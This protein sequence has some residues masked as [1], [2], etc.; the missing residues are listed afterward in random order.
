MGDVLN[1][2][3]H[4]LKTKRAK[5]PKFEELERALG[6]WFASMEAKKA[7]VTDAILVAKAK[8]FAS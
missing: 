8:E 5:K 6:L 7:I 3:T 2:D 1:T 4:Q